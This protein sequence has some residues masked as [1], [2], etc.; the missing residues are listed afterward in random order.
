MFTECFLYVSHCEKAR[1]LI[2]CFVQCLYTQHLEERLGC[3]RRSVNTSRL[4]A[5]SSKLF[6]VE[7]WRVSPVPQQ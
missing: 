4:K 7:G 5:S 6:E 2:I 3:I 1:A